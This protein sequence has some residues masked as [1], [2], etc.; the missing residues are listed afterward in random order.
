MF[1]AGT[2]QMGGRKGP[3][4]A[5]PSAVAPQQVPPEAGA[6]QQPPGAAPRMVIRRPIDRKV[7]PKKIIKTPLGEEKVEGGDETEE[8]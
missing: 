4:P 7:V 2:A 6:Q 3:P 8:Q 5:A 1:G